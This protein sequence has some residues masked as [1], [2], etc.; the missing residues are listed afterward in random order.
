[1]RSMNRKGTPHM[2]KFC[3]PSNEGDVS[4]EIAKK[5][6]DNLDTLTQIANRR[7]FDVMFTEAIIKSKTTVSYLSILMIDIDYLKN[8]NDT[9]G[10]LAADE[11]LRQV[12]L[13]LKDV[14]KRSGDLAARWDDEKFACILSDTDPAGAAQMAEKIRKKVIDLA[15]PTSASAVAEVVTVSIGV[16]TSILTDE[17]SY[18]KLLKKADQALSTARETGRNRIFISKS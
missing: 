14:L 2:K 11:C 9:D 12:A 8:L 4:K 18:D 1:M 15:I 6:S 7:K 16:V 3:D 10:K 5:T 13:T 17:T